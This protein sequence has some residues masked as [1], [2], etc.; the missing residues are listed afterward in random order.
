MQEGR[1]FFLLKKPFPVKKHTYVKGRE[2][3]T[4]SLRKSKLEWNLK[5]SPKALQMKSN[6]LVSIDET[7]YQKVALV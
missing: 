1:D 6:I 2:K 5:C 4:V 7:S 3:L